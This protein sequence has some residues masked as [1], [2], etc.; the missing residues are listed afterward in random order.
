M[1]TLDSLS[2]VTLPLLHVTP[3]HPPLQGSLAEDQLNG[4]LVHWLFREFSAEPVT[5]KSFA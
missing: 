4:A 2:D 1:L 3:S 5:K